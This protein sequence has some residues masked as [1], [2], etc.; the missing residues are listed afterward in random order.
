MDTDKNNAL[1]LHNNHFCLIWK[2]QGVSFNQAVEELKD[3]FEIADNY[4]TEENVNSYF[5]YEFT[6]IKIDSHLTIFIVYEFE[7]HNRD[8]ARPY[9]MTFFRISKIAGG[10]NCDLTA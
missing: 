8:K 5:N 10:Y 9:K 7:T 3:N 1:F 6:R 4:I 2:S